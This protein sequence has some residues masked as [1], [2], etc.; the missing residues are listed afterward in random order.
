MQQQKSQLKAKLW[1]PAPFTLHSHG[2]ARKDSVQRLAGLDHS[3]DLLITP[4]RK[5]NELESRMEVEPTVS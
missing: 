4:V 5:R 1:R 3:E 2:L